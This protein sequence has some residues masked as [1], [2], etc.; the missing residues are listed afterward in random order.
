MNAKVLSAISGVLTLLALC[1]VTQSRGQDFREEKRLHS[2]KSMSNK[3]VKDVALLTDDAYFRTAL[4]NIL[5]PRVVGTPS[6]TKVKNY[7]VNELKSLGWAVELD[8]FDS[9]TPTHGVLRFANII[10]RSAN[11][12]ARQL[13]LACHYDSKYFQQFEFLG[14]TDSAVPCAML[15]HLAKVLTPVLNNEKVGLTMIF[16]DGEEAF[17]EWSEWDSI[18]GSRN[19]AAKWSAQTF[20]R[21][22][23]SGNELDR[24]DMM[25]LLDLIG[26]KK[27]QFYSF[28]H[29]TQRWHSFMSKI[30]NKL[31]SMSLIPTDLPRLFWERSSFHQIEDDHKPFLKKQVPILHVF[32]VKFPKVWH[33]AKDDYSALDFPSIDAMNKIFQVFTYAYLHGSFQ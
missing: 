12:P 17:H 32:P 30:E 27:Q 13:V 22:G 16:F 8:E 21:D 23:I 11:S 6:H 15:L 28:F 24:I 9:Q 10:A 25:V 1:Y 26:V 33:T 31:K 7:I 18:Y 2:S 5:V 3:E 14:A 29:D 20:S 4:D 19:L